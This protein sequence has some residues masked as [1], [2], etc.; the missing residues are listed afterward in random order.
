MDKQFCSENSL[1]SFLTENGVSV[2]LIHCFEKLYMRTA[3]AQLNITTKD[4][5]V[6]CRPE[7]WLKGIFMKPWIPQ[8]KFLKEHMY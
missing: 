4:E 2:T 3:F 8:D 5:C 1:C 7:F 6:V